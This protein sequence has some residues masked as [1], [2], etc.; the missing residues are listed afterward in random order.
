MPTS[1][2]TSKSSCSRISFAR[3]SS[4]FSGSPLVSRGSGAEPSVGMKETERREGMRG[5][6]RW[7]GR[8][9][10]EVARMRPQLESDS[11]NI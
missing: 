7:G 5:V 3:A 4:T 11:V 9:D 10:P 1:T 2:R 8:R 6:E